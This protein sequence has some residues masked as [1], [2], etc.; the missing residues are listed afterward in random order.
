MEN[1]YK[2]RPNQRQVEAL[3]CPANE[4]FFGG[5]RGGGKTYFGII[6]FI[7][8]LF[9]LGGKAR[10]VA[11]RRT[12]GELEDIIEKCNELLKPLGF[13]QNIG[14]NV[15][16]HP[17]GAIYKLR[18]LEK[19]IDAERYQGHAYS[20]LF[21]DEVG[22][23][24]SLAGIDLLKSTLRGFGITPRIVVTA[25]PGGRAHKLLKSRYP[26][27]TPFE[28]TISL[29][30]WSRVF[31]PSLFSDNPQLVK[32]DPNYLSRATEDLPEFLR[33]AWE[34]GNWDITMEAGMYFKRK[35][36]KIE[37]I[38]PECKTYVR[39]WDR[40]ATELSEQNPD[41]DWTVGVLMG[42]TTLGE[43]FVLDVIRVLK[44]AADVKQL[45]RY[46][47][48]KDGINTTIKIFQDPGQAGKDQAEDMKRYLAGF[49]V[50]SIRET[51]E[52]HTRWNPF[53]SAVQN[54][55]CRLVDGDWNEDYID[56]LVSLTN[57]P[58]EYGHDDQADA[59]SGAFTYLNKP[60]V[61]DVY[62]FDDF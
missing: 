25:N 22:N 18:Y 11:F 2:I 46:T 59:S 43:T 45:I 6:D 7:K 56:E 3:I 53:S 50:E 29:K 47:A 48:V 51:G 33:Q 55:V 17:S 52:K 37:R 26:I 30:G 54:Q 9:T 36:F 23:Y 62:V 1:L 40:A 19:T 21:F 24:K 60:I 14:N 13:V 31:I 8:Q 58:S 27:K 4:I 5:A 39:C 41:P 16:A 44:R 10:G 42:K 12:F 28:P 61:S 49:T 15:Y 34:L 32:K 20:H 57:N 38:V 35:D